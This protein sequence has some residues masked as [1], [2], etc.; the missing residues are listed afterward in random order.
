MMRKVGEDGENEKAPD[1]L[2]YSGQ[3]C[4]IFLDLLDT[5]KD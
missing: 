3:H 1:M 5:N 4:A 2:I